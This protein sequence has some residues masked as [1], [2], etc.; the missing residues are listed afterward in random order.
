MDVYLWVE[1]KVSIHLIALSTKENGIQNK[2]ARKV[3]I[4]TID[5]APSTKM[6]EHMALLL[7]ERWH[8]YGM[9]GLSES[10][11]QK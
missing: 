8:Y 4:S 6:A 3:S 7:A 1:P 10:L 11:L 9:A 2:I 5:K